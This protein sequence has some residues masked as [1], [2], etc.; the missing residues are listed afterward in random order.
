M[1]ADRIVPTCWLV[2]REVQ[3]MR[4]SL[5][6]PDIHG[7]RVWSPEKWREACGG[8]VLAFLAEELVRGGLPPIF[9]VHVGLERSFASPR[10]VPVFAPVRV[11]AARVQDRVSVGGK[12]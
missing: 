3:R 7:G 1:S 4:S 6:I 10:T 12:S 5:A 2:E 8:R 9:P 11:F